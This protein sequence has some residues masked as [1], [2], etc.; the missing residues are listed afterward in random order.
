M[1]FEEL[2]LNVLLRPKYIPPYDKPPELTKVAILA[3]RFIYNSFCW[4][5]RTFVRLLIPYSE[6]T[7]F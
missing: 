3:G 5:I 7:V 2:F 6:E 4:M 1:I